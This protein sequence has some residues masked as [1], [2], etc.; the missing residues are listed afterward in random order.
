MD[1]MERRITLR[2][3]AYWERLRVSAAMPAEDDLDPGDIA[4]L[5]E[6]CF[7]I[8]T[9]KFNKGGYKF[10]YLGRAIEEV[11]K[12]E[13][14]PDERN[15]KGAEY[16]MLTEGYEEVLATKKPLVT[17]GVVTNNHGDSFK[18]RQVLLP[19][20]RGGQ[21]QAVFG[22]MRYLRVYSYT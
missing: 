1:G 13:E 3:L 20:G 9:A 8:H 19:L 15:V 16:Q 18:Y 2:L 4:D 22:G 12:P 11:Y 14:S 21:V 17:E 6:N 7:L 5:W 10:S